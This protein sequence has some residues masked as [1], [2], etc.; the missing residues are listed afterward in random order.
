MLLRLLHEQFP[1]EALSSQAFEQRSSVTGVTSTIDAHQRSL[2]D[3]PAFQ[4]ML[5]QEGS[6][7]NQALDLPQ[8]LPNLPP[9]ASQMANYGL[10]RLQSH[11]EEL[12]MDVDDVIK[13]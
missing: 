7:Q 8:V 12:R 4:Q 2:I 11:G 13:R 6:Q 3:S 5:G 10:S 9:G 1:T